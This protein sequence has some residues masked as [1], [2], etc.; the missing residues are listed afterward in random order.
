MAQYFDLTLDTTAPSS[1]SISFSQTYYK[2]SATATISAS[3]ATYMKVWVTQSATGS[4]S[5]TNFPSSWEVYNTS[6]SL[7]LSTQGT[8]YAHAVFMD[9]VGNISG[10]VNSG[11]IVY[12]NTAP[13]ISSVSINNGADYT[14][15]VSVTVR[16]TVSDSTS[17]VDY[18]TLSGDITQTGNAAKFVFSDSDRA[19]GY[20]DCSVTLTT[21]DGVKTVSATATDRSGNTSASSSDDITL[22]TSTAEIT[23]VLR[24]S[25]DTAN[26]GS[27]TN[28]S[29]FA[30][31]ISTEADD[32]VGYKIWGSIDG[33]TTEPATW[34]SGTWVE[35]R[36]LVDDLDFTSGEGTKTVYV[37][38]RDNAGNETETITVT[39]VYDIT[40]PTVTLSANPTVISAQ[41]GYDTTTF[42]LGATDT[43][44]LTG[45]NYVLKLGTTTIKTGTFTGDGMTV[46]VTEAEIVAISSGQGTKSFTLSIT[47]QAGN[48]GISSAVTV[49]VDLTAPTGSISTSSYYTTSTVT[50]TISGSDTGGATLSKMKAWIDSDTPSTWSDYSS[51]SKSF[52]S[53][54]EGQHTAHVQFQDSVGNT[55][56]TY[57]SSTFIVDSTAPTGTISCASYTNSRTLT[58]SVNASDDKA[59][60]VT[61]GVA[62][63]KVWENGTTEPSWETYTTSKTITLTSGDGSK[64]INAK[65]KDNAGNVS[66]TVTCNTILDTDSPDVTLTL[67]QSDNSTVLPAQVN[68]RDFVARIGYDAQ[69]TQ[70]SP[71]VAY[72][73]SGDFTQSSDEWQTYTPDTGKTYM[74]ITNLTLTATEGTKTISAWLKDS[75]GN[76]T[77]TA[78]VATVVYDV[79]LPVID[80]TV[81]PDFNIISKQHT[82]RLTHSGSTVSEVTGKYNDTVIFTW[83]PSEALR[84]YK[85][86]VNEEGQT[87][88]DAVAIGTAGGSLNVSGGS[89]AASANVTTT[90]MGADFAANSIVNDTDGAY[91]VIV[92]GQDIG[93]T[94]SAVHSIS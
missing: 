50:A 4:T 46:A 20:K 74:S 38:A 9:E 49:T 91:E 2:T 75:A 15:T 90:I 24:N 51:G 66:L 73:L 17:G 6:K 78:A 41:T 54:A 62:Q 63:M 45:V 3:G 19:A 60:I 65:F 80:I 61:S 70:D 30:A 59:G 83:S 43:N 55:S 82:I 32:L 16:V 29:S 18:V 53:I 71:I 67:Y 42:T 89:V 21:P 40:A 37:K 87:A 5:D 76:I 36:L 23:V 11:A 47:D 88:A 33:A 92:Y 81:N 12:D 44:P 72:K 31:A 85:V 25:A 68:Y 79:T 13:T 39:V 22:D 94:W 7:S 34:T 52:T 93:G 77:T 84:A 1:G 27:Y 64:T 14:D 69:E 28:Q 35:G 48:T 10:V 8:N 56:T 26:L 58:V 86:C 57:N